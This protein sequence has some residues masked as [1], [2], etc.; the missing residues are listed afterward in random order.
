MI[1][2]QPGRRWTG[3]ASLPAPFAQLP[4]SLR[5]RV[6]K[7]EAGRPAYPETAE[8]IRMSQ[9][10]TCASRPFSLQGSR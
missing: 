5:P 7:F 8:S 9:Q 4:A 10:T 1:A 3:P 6:V 2:E